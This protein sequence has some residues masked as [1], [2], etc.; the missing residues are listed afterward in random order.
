MAPYGWTQKSSLQLVL[1]VCSH[2]ALSGFHLDDPSE[3]SHTDFRRGWE[4]HERRHGIQ[5]HCRRCTNVVFTF[6][7]II[8][9]ITVADC[10]R[11]PLSCAS[12]TISCWSDVFI[13]TGCWSDTLDT[14]YH[15]FTAS[16]TTSS[17]GSDFS[18]VWCVM[19][20]SLSILIIIITV[21]TVVH[22]VLTAIS[23]F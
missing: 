2:L 23:Q 20:H 15:C 4:Q 16:S 21:W 10:R 1:R 12:V 5:R 18:R 13:C 7:F 14:A 3:L 17:T 19:I 22:T 9:N 11:S 8:R 6:S